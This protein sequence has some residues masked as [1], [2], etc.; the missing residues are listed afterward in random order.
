MPW[1][2]TDCHRT[3]CSKIIWLRHRMQVGTSCVRARLT[4]QSSARRALANIWPALITAAPTET[5][6]LM[7]SW[8]VAKKSRSHREIWSSTSIP[9]TVSFRRN[10]TISRCCSSTRCLKRQKR[11]DYATFNH[12]SSVFRGSESLPQVSLNSKCRA[13][14]HLMDQIRTN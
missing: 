12:S 7:S 1:L 14:Y 13:S 3:K 8:R 2:K 10:W 6:M 4:G 5:A 11:Q 9:R